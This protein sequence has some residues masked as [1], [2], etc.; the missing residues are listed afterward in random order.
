MVLIKY[1]FRIILP[2]RD[3]LKYSGYQA[4]MERSDIDVE[5]L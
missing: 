4:K 1:F 3:P 2:G 5:Y